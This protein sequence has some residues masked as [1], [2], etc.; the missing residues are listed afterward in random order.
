MNVEIV[1]QYYFKFLY[2]ISVNCG[3]L[4]PFLLFLNNSDENV[5]F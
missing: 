3:F 1:L 2:Q 4:S 5:R